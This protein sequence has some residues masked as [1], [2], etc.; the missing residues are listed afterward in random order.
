MG[1]SQAGKTKRS[2]SG[3]KRRTNSKKRKFNMGRQPT[4]TRIGA[5]KIRAVRVRGGNIKHKAL[6]L[7]NGN[8]AWGTEAV[9]RQTRILDVVYN[10]TSNELGRTKT[11]VKNAIV[12]VDAN[13]FRLWYESYYGVNIAHPDQSVDVEA[14]KNKRR[15]KK[16]L[17]RQASRDIQKKVAAQF[18]QGKLL[19]CISS[20]PGQSGCADGY[21]LE[22]DELDFYLRK[23]SHKKKK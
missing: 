22:G 4:M 13:P 12:V 11:L 20:R 18:A 19:A 6:R 10:A 17:A 5:E 3:A 9:T 21:I 7:D 16:I 1:I 2:K 15:R 8:Y 23:I 14:I